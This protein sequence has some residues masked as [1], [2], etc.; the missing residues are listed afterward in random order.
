MAR[1]EFP[2]EE[3][4]L[5]S[6][7]ITPL[8]QHDFLVKLIHRQISHIPFENL[9]LHYSHNRTISLDPDQLFRKIVEQGRGG[10]CL[11]INT[12]FGLVLRGLGFHVISVGGRVSNQ[13]KPD[14]TNPNLEF[15]GWYD[16]EVPD[17]TFR[18]DLTDVM[19]RTHMVNIVTIENQRYAVDCAFGNNGPTLPLPLLD[20]FTCRNTGDDSGGSEMLLRHESISGSIP[21][22]LLWVYYVR[23]NTSMP[24][25]PAYCF[26]E[27]EFLPNDF[28]VMNYYVSKSP[29][30][31]FTRILVCMKFLVD[32]NTDKIIGDIT[33]RGNTIKER[34]YGQSKVLLGLNSEADRIA[35]LHTYFGVELTGLEMEGING[36]VSQI[37]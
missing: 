18:C 1:I 19:S 26:G 34:K 31:W 16:A 35:A 29:D 15:G 7:K 9:G 17:K 37:H 4:Q 32:H 28:L 20:G 25:I 5:L 33:L 36:M 22:Q 21:A 3:R 23:F 27:V 14:N 6:S 8:Q 2:T 13:I 12:F 11:E 10:Y 24:W 30:S